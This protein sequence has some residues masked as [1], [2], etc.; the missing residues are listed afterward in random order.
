MLLISSSIL[1]SCNVQVQFLTFTVG[2]LSKLYHSYSFSILFLPECCVYHSSSNRSLL[3]VLSFCQVHIICRP[4]PT[5]VLSLLF[6]IVP[7]AS[8]STGVLACTS[9]PLQPF[10]MSFNLQGSSNIPCSS[11]LTECFQLC[12]SLLHSFLEMA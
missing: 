2:V 6:F 11:F 4:F 9:C 3:Q 12:S 7:C 8:R 1:S 10:L 5:R